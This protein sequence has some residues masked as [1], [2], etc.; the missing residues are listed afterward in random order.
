MLT[1]V[2]PPSLASSLHGYIHTAHPVSPLTHHQVLLVRLL[3]VG[4]WLPW[5]L[6]GSV[7]REQDLDPLPRES[8][9]TG[10]GCGHNTNSAEYYPHFVGEETEAPSL[11]K[12]LTRPGA[13]LGFSPVCVV[14]KHT[15]HLTPDALLG[16][17]EHRSLLPVRGG[18]CRDLPL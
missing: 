1:A 6:P 13:E 2:P 18:S 3:P 9:L 15:C 16:P 14:V 10:L 5:H 12:G 7:R 11:R 8:D 17:Q 4:Q